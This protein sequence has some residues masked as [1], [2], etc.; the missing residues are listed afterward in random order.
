MFLLLKA[1]YGL[2]CW[3]VGQQ[4]LKKGS[5]DLAKLLAKQPLSDVHHNCAEETGFALAYPLSLRLSDG[6]KSVN[7]CRK[8]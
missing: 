6:R 1:C 2:R 5:F 8:I 7:T 4:S 3:I